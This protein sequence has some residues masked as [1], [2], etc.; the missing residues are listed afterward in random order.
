MAN[1]KSNFWKDVRRSQSP[2]REAG[3]KARVSAEMAKLPLAQVM[4]KRLLPDFKSDAEEAKWWFD[5]QDELDKDFAQA[6]LEGR[7]RRRT[8]EAAPLRGKNL[9]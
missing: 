3:V 5:N 7:L 1:K 8:Q 2:E 6:S 4:E 9:G